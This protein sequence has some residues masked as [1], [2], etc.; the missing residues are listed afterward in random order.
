M[1]TY[2]T[3]RWWNV[4]KTFIIRIMHTIICV[5][6]WEVYES[7]LVW[8]ISTIKY[9]LYTWTIVGILNNYH[10]NSLDLRSLISQDSWNC[11]FW[12]L[13]LIGVNLCIFSSA[14]F[15]L[16]VAPC[17]SRKPWYLPSSKKSLF[18]GHCETGMLLHNSGSAQ[19]PPTVFHLHFNAFQH[20]LFSARTCWSEYTTVPPLL[21]SKTAGT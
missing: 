12:C 18:K 1:C 11:A 7:K 13:C 14:Y 21:S 6:F 17:W 3:T 4:Q 2:R 8:F 19:E 16:N 5:T 9:P 20:K 15:R 10:C